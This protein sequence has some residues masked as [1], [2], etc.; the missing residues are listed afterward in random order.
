MEHTASALI[1]LNRRR[2]EENLRAAEASQQPRTGVAPAGM[3]LCSHP[4]APTAGHVFFR[5]NPRCPE[6]GEYTLPWGR[7]RGENGDYARRMR[8]DPQFY[9]LASQKRRPYDDDD[10]R[11]R[12]NEQAELGRGT[13]GEG[14]KYFKTYG[15][16]DCC[17]LKPWSVF[18]YRI[19]NTS[20]VNKKG[21]CKLFFGCCGPRLTAVRATHATPR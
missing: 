15:V 8:G 11:A 10:Q 19:P 20:V 21:D 6:D 12:L 5:P 3:Q 18:K 14:M 16:D 2:W 17:A 9:K 13:D 1:D 4:L 7:Y